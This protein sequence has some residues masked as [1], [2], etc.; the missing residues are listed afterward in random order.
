MS[1]GV[2]FK[3]LVSLFNW[4]FKSKSHSAKRAKFRKYLDLYCK[5]DDYFSSIRLILPSLD[6]ERGSYSHKESVLAISLLDALGIFRD[7]EDAKKTH[8]L[9]KRWYKNCG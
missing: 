5:S 8:Q 7:S 6:R 4:I 2:Q 9:A 3:V 1:D